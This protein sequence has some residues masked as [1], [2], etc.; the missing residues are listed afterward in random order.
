MPKATLPLNNTQI[1]NAKKKDKEYNLVDGDGLALRVKTNGSKIWIFNY[2]HPHT[3]KRK[4]ISVGSY[5]EISLARARDKRKEYR[6]LLIDNIDPKNHRDTQLKQE[7]EA[8][9]NT[10]EF[11]GS[12]WFEVKK[13]TVSTD[14]AIDVMRS[15][16]NHIF[17]YLGKV[18]ITQISAQDTIKK[19]E[20]LKAKGQFETLKRVIQRLNEIMTF[21]VNTGLLQANCLAGISKAFEKP[22]TKNFA[23]IKPEELA[24]FLKALSRAQ[25]KRV[26]RCLIEWQLHTMVRPGEAVLAK[27]SEIDFENKLW[28]IPPENMK[29]NRE[30][31]VPL[32]EQAMELLGELKDMT[33]HREY[34]FPADR[35]PKSHTNA[36]TANAAIKRMGY[37]GKLVAHGLRSIASTALNEEGFS[38]DLIEYCLAHVEQ[39]EVRRAYNRSEYIEQRRPLMQWWS[40]F[41]SEAQNQR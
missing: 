2:Y 26:T 15:L 8:H 33:R 11:V 9:T 36:Q 21:A 29:K 20:P 6:A 27:W 28:K 7:T 40:D 35:D 34:I 25:I 31:I 4:N 18:P 19:L 38:P 17:P 5:P 10:L 3:K 30:H 12:Q 24:D 16:E 32:S 23:S 13:T 14:Y 41:I 37:E 22:K 1:Q 39:N